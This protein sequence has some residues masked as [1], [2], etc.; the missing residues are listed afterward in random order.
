MAAALAPQKDTDGPVTLTEAACSVSCFMKL[1]HLGV[2]FPTD[3]YGQFAG[4]KTDHDPR[5][6]ATSAGPLTSKY[7][8]ELLEKKVLKKGVPVL[9][10]HTVVEVAVVNNRIEG[11]IAVHR[12]KPV[13][14]K[15][16]KIIWCTGGPAGI[17]KNSVYPESQRGMSGILLKA[18]VPGVN[19][20]YWQYGIASVSFRWNL[21]GTYQQVLPRYVSVDSEGR[22]REFLFEGAAEPK[23][24]LMC[25]FLKGYQWPFD[26]A[27]MNGSSLID[28]LVH[29]E[30][31]K[32][33]RV[34]L[35]YRRN[36]SGL[37]EDFSSLSG[38]A[39]Q[40]LKN[41]GA[42]FG[43]P[44]ER[45][46]HMNP[47]AV[48]LY[49]DHGIDLHKEMLEIRVCAQNHNGGL[50]VDENWQSPIQGLY[51]AG[52]A[53]G[54]FGAYRP[55]GS[56]L[57]SAQVGSM[58]A[59]QHI[60]RNPE[61][62]PELPAPEEQKILRRFAPPAGRPVEEFFTVYDQLVCQAAVLNAMIKAA[63]L[64]GSAGGSAAVSRGAVLPQTG[65]ISFRL[66]TIWKDNSA[67][68]QKTEARAVPD[69]PVWFENV[70]AE[71]RK[72]RL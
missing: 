35:D 3:R 67:Q 26:S 45:L 55:G 30:T 6:R 12:G 66:T 8:T 21:S 16:R 57:N 71:F 1:V 38:E 25:V 28:I 69:E 52:E 59:A 20:Q 36:P 60:L 19:L 68:T 50:L 34:Y 31:Q 18:G 46:E 42:L 70:W 61:K 27:K 43:T 53:A 11:L 48:Q 51:I 47:Q 62:P 9:D 56:A 29:E 33:R 23:D 13:Y 24:I 39:Y 32:G 22:E 4:Y 40:Y 44:I 65:N 63:S 2:P 64:S 10:D 14:L 58:R 5:M 49:K 54:T 41:S 7:M 72:E 15:S 17:Y 37:T